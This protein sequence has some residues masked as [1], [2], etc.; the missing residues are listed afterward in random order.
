MKVNLFSLQ[1]K[2]QSE[3]KELK[4]FWIDR[5]TLISFIH[6][7]P[8]ELVLSDQDNFVALKQV[9]EQSVVANK[10]LLKSNE[11]QID[12]NLLQRTVFVTSADEAVRVMDQ[13]TLLLSQH[14][15]RFVAMDMEGVSLGSE[16]GFLTLVQMAVTDVPIIC[17]DQDGQDRLF[18]AIPL[19]RIT[20][21]VFDI[22]QDERILHVMS[23]LFA[24][25]RVVKVF[26]GCA[27]DMLEL[28]KYN[29]RARNVF[30]TLVASR[31]LH[32]SGRQNIYALYELYTGEETNQ[33]KK[34]IKKIYFGAPDIW[35]RRP[36]DNKL[37]YYAALDAYALLQTYVAMKQKMHPEQHH[38]LDE[39]MQASRPKNRKRK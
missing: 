11:M 2:L 37:L 35:A 33:L 8:G 25:K 29:I 23:S 9:Y 7:F 26:H 34:K 18:E 1:F 32:D 17:A 15:N 28:E 38:Q 10:P 19:D 20:V 5:S 31:F 30:D 16:T 3:P 13:V 24:D 21:Y 39:L 12:M 6:Q 14:P 22:M 36:L 4:R 27:N